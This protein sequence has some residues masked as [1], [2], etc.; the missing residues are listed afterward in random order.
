MDSP[1]WAANPFVRPDDFIIAIGRKQSNSVYHVY[2]VRRKHYAKKRMVRHYMKVFKSD[3]QT[4]LNRDAQQQLIPMSW[5]SR[6]KKQNGS[7]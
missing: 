7:N 5:Y 3:L 1:S 4:A 6:E 2:S